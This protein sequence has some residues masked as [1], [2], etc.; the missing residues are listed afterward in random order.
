MTIFLIRTFYNQVPCERKISVSVVVMSNMAGG[1]VSTVTLVSGNRCIMRIA[2][3]GHWG[4]MRN[5]SNWSYMMGNAG[6][7]N[8]SS[9][10]HS[11]YVNWLSDHFLHWLGNF[12]VG[13]LSAN[14]SI[15]S[16]VMVSVIIDNT[17]MTIGIQEGVLTTYLITVAGLVLTLDVS[18]VT[19]VD[20][21]REFV[22]CWSMMF[23]LLHNGMLNWSSMNSSN[24][25]NWSCVCRM[26]LNALMR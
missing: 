17:M 24:M 10:S 19:I 4:D 18:S 25:V 13:G 14:H 15:E 23:D 1:L 20:R 7:R 9:V 12:Y 8:G 11:G 22:V 5:V 26:Q 2:G 16:T 6:M 3:V 21:I